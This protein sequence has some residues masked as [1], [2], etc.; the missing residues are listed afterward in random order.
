MNESNM[1][2]SAIEPIEA[3]PGK[4]RDKRLPMLWFA[5]AMVVCCFL[6]SIRNDGLLYLGAFACLA[7]V[8]GTAAVL[9]R[10]RGE[11]PSTLNAPI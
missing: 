3:K 1:S 10:T 11:S 7:I 4:R 9:V 8:L 2:E 6:V 5:V